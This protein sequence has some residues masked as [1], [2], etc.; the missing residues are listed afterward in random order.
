MVDDWDLRKVAEFFADPPIEVEDQSEIEAIYET[1]IEAGDDEWDGLKDPSHIQLTGVLYNLSEDL[2]RDEG[3]DRI[4]ELNERVTDRDLKMVHEAMRHYQLANAYSLR[5]SWSDDETMY[6]FFDSSDMIEAIGHA[7]ASVAQ[8]YS[9]V[10]GATR[11][12]QSFVNFAS[13]LS[14]T[15]R[16]CEA[17]FWYNKAIQKRPDNPMS[18]GN[19]GQCKIHY[20]DLLFSPNHTVRL[21]HSAYRDL[22]KALEN[23][24]D[25]HPNARSIF[26]T[27]MRAIEDYTDEGLNIEHEDESDL[28]ETPFDQEYH[29]WVLENHLYLNPLNDIYTHTSTAQDL[30]HLPDMVISNDEDFPYPGIYNQIKQEYVSARYLYYEGIAQTEESPHFSDREVKLPDTL[31]YSIYGYRT[32]QIKTAL[33]IAYSIFDKIAVLI[34]EYFGVGQRK[35]N[36]QQV[37]NKNGDYKQ[38]LVEPFQDSDNWALNALYW[39]KKDFHH[40]ISKN[41]EDS[42]VIVAH[43]LKSLRNAVEH[44]YIKVFED[45]IVSSP[46]TRD[47]LSDS[48]Y[49]AI[50]KSELRKAGLEML[51]IVRAAMIYIGLAIHHEERKKKQELDGPT[52]P[53]GGQMMIP[54]ELKQ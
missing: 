28:G 41:D 27:R 3:L 23:W 33:R 8:E 47:W 45:D 26:E 1:L 21:L 38:G 15:G 49:D 19:R 2:G 18:L 44:D 30:F 37:W 20:A 9:T 16:V 17:L 13:H 43:E 53:M 39:I 5:D 50:G 34:N 24:N 31:D 54:D 46:P 52:V 40:S 6:T 11:E 42:V 48:L 36:Y 35:T 7:R 51:R 25:P 4:I 10:L 29:Q 14:R 22:K 32:E 12:A